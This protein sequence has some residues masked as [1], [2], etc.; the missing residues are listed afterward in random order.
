MAFE[1]IEEISK[2]G[3]VLKQPSAEPSSI[4]E[5]VEPNSEKFEALLEQKGQ[6]NSSKVV[7]ETAPSST[8]APSL[9]D[10]IGKINGKVQKIA[11][12]SPEQ[13]QDQTKKLI[14]QIDS[15]KE[16]LSSQSDLNPAYQNVLKN[17]LSH[18]DDSL[19]IALSKAGVEYT[20]PESVASAAPGGG[21][22]NPIER[23]L[24]FLT[25]SQYQLEHLSQTIEALQLTDAKLSPAS[26]LA[27]Q[28]K[29][30]YVQQ[31][32]ELFTSMLNK[33]LESTKTIMNVQ[34]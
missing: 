28:I 6:D 24:G 13:L 23:F 2:L 34:V 22:A 33:S 9:I 21:A 4:I 17:R 20:P 32:M 29:V 10:E 25:S 31:Q 5:R 26:M 18:I 11:E 7:A 3:K 1:K 12:L 8:P 15:V 14:A 16:H 19:K 27:I 30:G